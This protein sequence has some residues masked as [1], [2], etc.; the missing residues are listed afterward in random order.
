MGHADDGAATAVFSELY[1]TH[2]R[3]VHRFALF[4][5]GDPALADDITSET[6]VRMWNARARVDLTTVKAYLFAIA[7]NLF[8]HERRR[9]GRVTALDDAMADLQPGP[10]ARAGAR[11]ELRTVLAALQALP[12]ADRAAVL[13]RAEAGM[14]YG[15]IGR[16]L[17]M[18]ESAAKVRVHRA[19]LKLAAARQPA[20]P[21]KGEEIER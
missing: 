6:F 15:E 17:G 12:E 8:L 10:D 1:R 20:L 4:L 7:R 5:S 18:S 21:V 11:D 2:A 9:A 3:D 14:P 13:M 19:R 16:A